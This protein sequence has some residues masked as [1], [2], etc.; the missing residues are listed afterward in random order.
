MHTHAPP[1]EAVQENINLQAGLFGLLGG[2]TH[3]I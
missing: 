1:S 2:W 3:F